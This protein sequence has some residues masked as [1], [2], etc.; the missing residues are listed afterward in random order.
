MAITVNMH[1]D[2]RVKEVAGFKVQDHVHC[3]VA[4]QSIGP[5]P[6]CSRQQPK[7]VYGLVC[8]ENYGCACPGGYDLDL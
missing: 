7:Y 3:A 4:R 1:M 8:R 6:S 5:L 2:I